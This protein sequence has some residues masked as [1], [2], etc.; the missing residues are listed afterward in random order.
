MH[1][2]N[3]KLSFLLLV[4]ITLTLTACGS[5]SS[6]S[7]SGGG[8]GGGG[9]GGSSDTKPPTVT[10]VDPPDGAVGV[11]TDKPIVATFSEQISN[12]TVN[13]TSFFIEDDAGMP[14]DGAS[15]APS[16]RKAFFTP[17]AITFKKGTLYHATLTT[18]I[19]D[20]AGNHLAADKTW[21]FRTLVDE[22]DAT[23]TS[24]APLPRTSHTAVWTGDEMIIWGGDTSSGVTA[25]GGRYDP[26][27]NTWTATTTTTTNAPSARTDHTAVWTGSKM[28][29]WGGADAGGTPTITGAVYNPGTSPGTDTWTA[30]PTTM[31]GGSALVA[32]RLHTAVWTGSK[33]IVWGGL[34][35]GNTPTNTG[36]IY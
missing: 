18:G 25:T 17:S 32:R 27:D 19:T 2:T 21:T 26:V 31:T 5:S 15:V 16:G 7:S 10:A 6:T 9:G 30:L 20:V 14:A 1:R 33:M 22:W 29:V 23:T 13:T 24:S 8:G 28:I 11:A 34:A 36:A 3:S 12:S 4:L 35:T